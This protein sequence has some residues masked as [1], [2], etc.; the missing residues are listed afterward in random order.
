MLTFQE[1]LSEIKQRSANEKLAL[2]EEIAHWLREEMTVLDKE[3][4]ALGWPPG[5]FEQTYGAFRDEPLE[6]GPQGEYP[7]REELL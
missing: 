3:A 6:R 1:L 2:M 4:E 5:Y 7:V